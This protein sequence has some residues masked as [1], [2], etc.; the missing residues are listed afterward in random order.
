MARLATAPHTTDHFAAIAQLRWRLFVN[1][2]HRR[3]GKAELIARIII[4]PLVAVYSIGPILVS[5]VA[6]YFLTSEG[7][8]SSIALILWTLSGIWVFLSFGGAAGQ[9]F[10]Q[11]SGG[12]FDPSQ[13]IRFPISFPSYLIF[14]IFFGVLTFT[15]VV[16]FLCLLSASIGIGIAHPSLFPWAV[17][18]LFFFG[19]AILFFLRTLLL[20]MDRWLAQRRTRELFLA[21]FILL[22]LSIQFVSLSLRPHA[23]GSNTRLG[24]TSR[25]VLHAVS[26]ILGPLVPYLPPTLA[27][28][29]IQQMQ[30]AQPLAAI[31]ALLELIAYPAIFLALYAHRLRGEFRGENFSETAARPITTSATR[32]R[33]SWSLFGLPPTIAA[34]IEKEV[35]Y[36]LRGGPLLIN[37]ITPLFF[38]FIFT[39]RAGFLSKTGTLM[40]PMAIAYILLGLFAPLYNSLGAD[41]NGVSLYLMA[42]V[43]FRHVFIAKNIVNVAVI[44][45]EVLLATLIVTLQHPPSTPVVVATLL[46][47]IFAVFVNLSTG[48][49]RSLYAPQ[50]M[51]IGKAARQPTSRSGGLISIGILFSSLLI[52]VAV[53]W[54]CNHFSHPWLAAP[55]FLALAA[56]AFIAYILVLNRIDDVALRQRDTLAEELCKT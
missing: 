19:T 24:N 40:F 7:K 9:S 33:L 10:A 12:A 25:F 21:L 55:I 26:P 50:K 48:N 34:C 43:R 1:A 56:A 28:H 32:S 36:L 22:S 53:L 15:N 31:T 8:I 35:R 16:G 38:V 20:W 39:N 18:V 44:S 42:P 4:Y 45:I 37:L 3:G 2:F 27:T 47:V 11:Q 54:T 49:L 13:L 52:C 6:A 5:G 17:L 51:Q 30:T 14:R 29:S 46:W 41:A 23:V